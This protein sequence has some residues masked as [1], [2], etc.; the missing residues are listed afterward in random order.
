MKELKECLE[1][2]KNSI[3]TLIKEI[4]ENDEKIKIYI[5]MSEQVLEKLDSQRKQLDE[6]RNS[7]I[8]EIWKKHILENKRYGYEELYKEIEEKIK[9]F[10]NRLKKDIE[11]FEKDR[12]KIL[13]A[14][15]KV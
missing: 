15:K 8:V 5:T 2:L 4:D 11:E 1:K 6:F 13:K 10:D 7:N 9:E 12:E 3:D 14:N